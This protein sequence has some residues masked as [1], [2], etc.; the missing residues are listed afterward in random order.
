LPPCRGASDRPGW[1]LRR[2]V[3]RPKGRRARSARGSTVSGSPSPSPRGVP[4]HLPRSAPP[5]SWRSLRGA[6]VPPVDYRDELRRCQ[7]VHHVPEHLSTMSPAFT[8]C[9]RGGD[10]SRRGGGGGGG[11]PRTGSPRPLT[12]ILSPGRRAERIRGASSESL[13]I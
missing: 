7:P 12:L 6:R 10:P 5:D 9:G 11:A 4:R 3:L 2:A 1:L 8:H 13:T